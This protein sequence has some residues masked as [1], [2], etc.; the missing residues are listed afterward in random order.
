M[1][2]KQYGSFYTKPGEWTVNV[3]PGKEML[4]GPREHYKIRVKDRL[5][6]P[7]LGGTKRNYWA[8]A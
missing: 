1:W 7:V 6:R 2:E 8:A 3:Q 4:G 5:F